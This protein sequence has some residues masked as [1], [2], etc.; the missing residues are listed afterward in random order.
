MKGKEAWGVGAGSFGKGLRLCGQEFGFHRASSRELEGDGTPCGDDEGFHK[1]YPG[2]SWESVEWK[3]EGFKE[4][5]LILCSEW[6][7]FV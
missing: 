3:G 2:S 5:D 4:T 6:D 7:N 1:E